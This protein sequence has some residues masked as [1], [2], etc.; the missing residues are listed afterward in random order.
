M[1]LQLQQGDVNIESTQIPQEAVKITS[2][3]IA[4]GEA[5]GHAHRLEGDAY[6]LELGDRIFI[7]VLSGNA[8]VIHEEHGPI[9]LPPGQYE[10]SIVYEMDHFAHEARQVMD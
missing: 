10:T 6:L 2:N 7:N 1:K 3:V 9:T 8:R 5:T 4:Q